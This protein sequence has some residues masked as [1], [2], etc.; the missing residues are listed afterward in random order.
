MHSEPKIITMID[1]RLETLNQLNNLAIKGNAI[2][3]LLIRYQSRIDEL[4]SLR[5]QYQ[6][7][8][9]C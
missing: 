2:E 7:W 5:L 3:S 1:E 9:K 6:L 4:K 8:N